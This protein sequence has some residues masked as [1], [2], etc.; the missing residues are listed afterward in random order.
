MNLNDWI[1]V[2]LMKN[3]VIPCVKDIRPFECGEILVVLRH[4]LWFLLTSEK[5]LLCVVVI[6][7]SGLFCLPRIL[8]SNLRCRKLFP[9]HLWLIYDVVTLLFALSRISFRAAISLFWMLHL[10]V[11]AFRFQHFVH[12]FKIRS[13][14]RWLWKTIV[15]ATTHWPWVILRIV[16]TY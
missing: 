2:I 13:K 8:T 5:V 4:I 11:H 6:P 9:K 10:P 7:V 14:F 3:G 1:L 15:A 16:V 12:I